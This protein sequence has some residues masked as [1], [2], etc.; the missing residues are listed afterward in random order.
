M[1]IC[2]KYVLIW[3]FKYSSKWVK[4]EKG[5]QYWLPF[6]KYLKYFQIE[7]IY[8]GKRW[9]QIFNSTETHPN[10]FIIIV[11]LYNFI[12]IVEKI[13]LD[14]HILALIWEILKNVKSDSQRKPCDKAEWV[15]NVWKRSSTHHIL[16]IIRCQYFINAFKIHMHIIIYKIRWLNEFFYFF[17]QST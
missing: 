1:K 15:I 12:I 10:N 9:K 13:M 8:R 3:L 14:F 6:Q 16:V 5:H 4:N 7:P 17:H 11:V 2:P